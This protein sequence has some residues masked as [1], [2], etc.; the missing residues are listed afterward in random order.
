LIFKKCWDKNVMEILYIFIISLKY[1]YI[2]L[3]YKILEINLNSISF[4]LFNIIKYN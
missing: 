1:I 4:E 2:L 3:K